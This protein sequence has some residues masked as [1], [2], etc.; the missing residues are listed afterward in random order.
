MHD[1]TT[2]INMIN[3]PEDYNDVICYHNEH[4][5]RTIYFRYRY[6]VFKLVGEYID[7]QGDRELFLQPLQELDDHD[8]RS[9][10]ANIH[11]VKI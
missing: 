7:V 3:Y 8:V 1:Q 9:L 2:L 6:R 5:A 11:H 10:V 4:N